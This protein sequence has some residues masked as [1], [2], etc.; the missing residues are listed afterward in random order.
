[1]GYSYI[2]VVHANNLSTAYGHVSQILVEE[3]EFVAKGEVIGMSGG[4]PGTPGAGNL[5]TGPHLHF[6]V[7]YDGI[8][9]D[10]LNYLPYASTVD[11]PEVDNF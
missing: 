3:D 6:E 1:M 5:S 10:P 9:V 8:P 4:A 7:R 11:Y 2:I